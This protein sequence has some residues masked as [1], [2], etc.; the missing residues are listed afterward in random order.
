MRS[1]HLLRIL[2]IAAIACWAWSP[3]PNGPAVAQDA[4]PTQ[5]EGLEQLTPYL[6]PQL[7]VRIAEG[8]Q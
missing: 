8:V 3:A 1:R 5:A 7:M 2:A 4:A 6:K